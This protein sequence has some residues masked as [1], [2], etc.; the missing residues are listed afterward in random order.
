MKRHIS[1]KINNI[2]KLSGEFENE[3][4]MDYCENHEVKKPKQVFT[5]NKPD[6]RR[7][8]LEENR[9]QKPCCDKYQL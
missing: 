5:K 2:P 1:K 8:F 4:E 7:S 9:S 3:F 6:Y